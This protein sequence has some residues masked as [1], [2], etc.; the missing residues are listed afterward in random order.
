MQ[1]LTSVV[2]LFQF[3]I[4]SSWYEDQ[5]LWYLNIKRHKFEWN[6]SIHF[7][8]LQRHRAVTTTSMWQQFFLQ[9]SGSVCICYFKRL[10]SKVKEIPTEGSFGWNIGSSWQRVLFI[11]HVFSCKLWHSR[12][13]LS[14]FIWYLVIFLQE[15]NVKI[16]MI[17]FKR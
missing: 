13:C 15:H 2:L 4:H 1:I 7:E 10:Y 8:Q 12:G 5:D 17:C 3:W 6:S 16:N 14:K 11:I 9:I